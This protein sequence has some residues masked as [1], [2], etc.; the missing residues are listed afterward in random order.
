MTLRTVDETCLLTRDGNCIERHVPGCVITQRLLIELMNERP[1]ID[2]IR[3]YNET[4]LQTAQRIRQSFLRM[5]AREQSSPG[6]HL[7]E[8]TAVR[9]QLATVQA[10]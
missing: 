7:D 4:L 1:V 6:S 2:G 5:V 3:Q 8:A 9:D 10:P